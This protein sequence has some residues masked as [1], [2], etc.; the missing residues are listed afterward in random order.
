MTIKTH[1]PN[2]ESKYEYDLVIADPSFFTAQLS[3]A[4]SAV[5]S[6]GAPR[7]IYE[8]ASDSGEMGYFH[9]GRKGRPVFIDGIQDLGSLVEDSYPLKDLIFRESITV[10]DGKF[11]LIRSAAPS[12]TVDTELSFDDNKNV[13]PSLDARDC[14][15]DNLIIPGGLR[16]W[17]TAP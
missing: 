9:H 12:L 6:P 15:F 8:G 17:S 10:T 16:A 4:A 2:R 13:I 5:L 11:E 14:L 3:T 7:S 1:Y